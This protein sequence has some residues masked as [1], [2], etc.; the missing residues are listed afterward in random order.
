MTDLIIRPVEA[1]EHEAWDAFIRTSQTGTLFHTSIWKSVIDAAYDD[2]LYTLIGAYDNERLVGGFCA[3]TRKRLGVATAVTPLSTPYTGFVLQRENR[4]DAVQRE[5]HITQ[6]FV[7]YLRRYR[8]QNLQCVPG[9]ATYGSPADRIPLVDLRPLAEAGYTITARWTLMID[10]QQPEEKLWKG[11][12]GQ[13]RRNIKKAEKS[14]FE[15]NDKWDR[16]RAYEIFSETFGRHGKACPVPEKLFQVIADGEILMTH[17]RRYCAWRDG[18]MEAFLVA[19]RYNGTVYYK[20]ASTSTEVLKSGISSLLIWEMLKD[21]LDGSW[22]IFDFVGANIPSI[23]RFKEG[24][25]PSGSTY[26]AAEY[27]SSRRIALALKA[28]KLLRL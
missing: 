22:E 4:A 9:P 12:E 6:A 27:C 18:R 10:L 1:S 2:G 24:F 17:R 19:L 23:A 21:H 3:L 7:P 20:F 13:V 28:R 14:G 8:Y 26:H 25:H 16:D 5:D 15:I 11:F